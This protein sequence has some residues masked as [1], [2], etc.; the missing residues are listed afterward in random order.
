MA[1]K[2]IAT[3]VKPSRERDRG[4]GRYSSPEYALTERRRTRGSSHNGLC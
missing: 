1:V 2:K 4:K 3:M